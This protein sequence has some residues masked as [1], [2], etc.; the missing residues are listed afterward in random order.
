MKI[1][2]DDKVIIE[3][4]AILGLAKDH[5][6]W[7]A[8]SNVAY[9]FYPVIDFN[10]KKCKDCP[11]KC[12]VE[13]MCPKK[14]FKYSEKDKASVLTENYWKTCNLCKACEENCQMDLIKLSWKDDTHI[15]SIESDGV[16][17]F[18]VLLKKVFEIYMEKIQ[19]FTT[20]LEEL[21][22]ET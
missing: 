14:L 18:D 19:E 3:A 17:P 12:L 10:N 2:K 7:Q 8:V 13:R 16:L 22:I 5:V 20:K 21:E 4:Y 6:K 1:D 11:D 15:F 9:R